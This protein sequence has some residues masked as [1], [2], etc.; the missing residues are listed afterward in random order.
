MRRRILI[1]LTALVLAGLSA[2]ALLVYA[3]GVDRRAVA[4]RDA[5]WVLLAGRRIPAGTTGA[6]IRD[7]KLF[8]R[9]LMPAETV[10]KGTLH[11]YDASLDGLRLTA[12]LQPRQLLMR[13]QFGTQAPPSAARA[14]V[15]EGKLAVSIAVTMAPGVAEQVVAGDQVTV[16]VTYPK[17]QP[18][19]AQQTRILLPGATVLSITTGPSGDVPPSPAATR[20]SGP[21]DDT[22]TYP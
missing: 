20:R 1:A 16:F 21:A 14:G 17:D 22:R 7:D 3:R 13:D 15:P 6:R 2:M 11:A 4:G 18:P 12:D 9:V 8:D 10:P 5:V 19:S